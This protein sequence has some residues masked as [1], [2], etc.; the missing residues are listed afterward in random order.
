MPGGLPS[1]DIRSWTRRTCLTSSTMSRGE[2]VEAPAASTSVSTASNAACAVGSCSAHAAASTRSG[3]GAVASAAARSGPA[4]RCAMKSTTCTGSIRTSG[5]AARA[6]SSMACQAVATIGRESGARPLVAIRWSTGSIPGI[7]PQC[8]HVE[9]LD[10]NAVQDL[11]AGALDSGARASAIAH[12]D[13]CPDCRDLISLLARDATRDAAEDILRE[14]ADRPRDI[15]MLETQESRPPLPRGSSGL[16]ATAAAAAAAD[17]IGAR[18]VRTPRM[19]GHTLGRYTMIDRL[20]AGAMGVVYR[21]ED[22][23]LGRQIALKLLHRPD[24]A[25]TDRLVREAR[26]MAQ[27]NHPNVVD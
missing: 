11:M 3:P 27:V 20:G 5:H 9:C 15:S 16:L 26:S 6:A 22:E 23:G 12:I 4:R 2:R 24:P 10:A 18:R 14:T 1:F 21:A 13:G 8:G 25:L 19:T 7:V 17:G